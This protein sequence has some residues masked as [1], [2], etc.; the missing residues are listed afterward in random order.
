MTSFFAGALG[1]I[2]VLVTLAATRARAWRRFHHGH[3]GHGVRRLARRI[4]ATPHQEALLRGEA[5]AIFAELSGL[6]GELFGARVELAELL[7]APLTERAAFEG[8]LARQGEKLARTRGRIAEAIAKV[9]DSLDAEQRKRL[10]ELVRRGPRHRH[11]G[12]AH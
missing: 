1:A 7:D 5:E 8:M 2:A 4:G 9:H 11:H 10:A 3:R 12:F 6:R